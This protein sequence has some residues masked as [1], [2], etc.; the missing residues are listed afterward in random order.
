MLVDGFRSYMPAD[1]GGYIRVD[2]AICM[3]ISRVTHRKTVRHPDAGIS[4]D[5]TNR[6]G[7]EIKVNADRSRI[8]K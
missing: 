7:L 6:N 5:R 2:G 1:G 8:R 4:L 3:Y